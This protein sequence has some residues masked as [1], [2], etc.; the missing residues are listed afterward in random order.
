NVNAIPRDG[1]NRFSGT[2]FTSYMNDSMQSSNLTQ[3][4]EDRGLDFVNGVVRMYD[5]NGVIS[6]PI[7][8][9]RI[10][11][12][13]AHRRSGGATRVANTFRDSDTTDWFFTPDLSRPLEPEELLRSH[14]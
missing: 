6:G 9:D 12:M 1:G 2:W 5:L 7:R 11:F 8:S 14:N 13:T 4:L 10:F 3:R